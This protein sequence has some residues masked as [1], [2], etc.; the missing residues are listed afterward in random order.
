MNTRAL[1]LGGLSALLLGGTMVGCASNG[2][3]VASASD[4]S[5]TLAAKGAATNAGKAQA[6]LARREG[7]VAIG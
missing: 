5:G 3:G 7:P 6:A 1:L 2:G 4:R